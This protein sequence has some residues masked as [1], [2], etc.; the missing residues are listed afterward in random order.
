MAGKQA[1][2][3][4]LYDMSGN[5]WEWTEDCWNAN[6][7]GAP[8]DG[9]AWTSG[10]CSVGRVLRGGSW[11]NAPQ[12]ARSATRSRSDSTGRGYSFGFRLARML[13]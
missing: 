7:S 12:V 1:N 8:R 9:S 2:A 11:G 3:F 6:Y 10:Q 4:G 13:P 5:V